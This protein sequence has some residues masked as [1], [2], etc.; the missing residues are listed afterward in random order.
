MWDFQP[1]THTHTQTHTRN[2]DEVDKEFPWQKFT[3]VPTK[4]RTGVE[5]TN[6]ALPPK[7]GPLFALQAGQTRH[8]HEMIPK[9]NNT[10]ATIYMK[11]FV[12]N[13]VNGESGIAAIKL[14]DGIV[15]SCNGAVS[16]YP[17]R[18]ATIPDLPTRSGVLLPCPRCNSTF[19]TT[20]SEATDCTCLCAVRTAYSCRVQR[21]AA[22]STGSHVYHKIEWKQHDK[23]SSNFGARRHQM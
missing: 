19:L 3:H 4:V 18:R 1:V 13:C 23:P 10:S 20:H 7:D 6:L 9:Y 16:T 11:A 15:I 17:L 8:C 12:V 22:P 2:K 5:E 21:L 14:S